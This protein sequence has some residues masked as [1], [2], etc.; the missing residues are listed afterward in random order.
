MNSIVPLW[1]SFLIIFIY[2]TLIMLVTVGLQRVL[3]R[4]QMAD[5]HNGLLWVVSS[6][7]TAWLSLAIVLAAQG[8]F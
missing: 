6:F 5:R 3:L 8:F 2:I 7:L 4:L 1:M